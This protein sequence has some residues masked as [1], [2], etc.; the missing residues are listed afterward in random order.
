MRGSFLALN[1]AIDVYRGTGI[2]PV[3]SYKIKS[4]LRLIRLTA[5][6]IPLAGPALG[7]VRS[8]TGPWPACS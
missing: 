6:P 4:G 5:L 3:E 7:E 8:G 2:L 1:R